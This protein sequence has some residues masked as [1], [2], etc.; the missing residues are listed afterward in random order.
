MLLQKL[1]IGYA[2]FTGFKSEL[3]QIWRITFDEVGLVK[4]IK[5][6]NRDLMAAEI[7]YTF[8]KGEDERWNITKL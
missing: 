2:E 8:E 5:P 7:R 1:H 4:F 3:P 6:V